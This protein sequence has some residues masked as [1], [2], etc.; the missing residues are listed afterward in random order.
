MSSFHICCR[1]EK[2]F[3]AGERREALNARGST[4]LPSTS[5]LCWGMRLFQTE[6]ATLNQ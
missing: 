1:L 5:A 3:P 6:V 2:H 4:L